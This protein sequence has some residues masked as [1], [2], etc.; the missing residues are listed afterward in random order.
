MCAVNLVAMARESLQSV[1]LRCSVMRLSALLFGAVTSVLWLLPVGCCCAAARPTR[2]ILSDSFIL[3]DRFSA[4][5]LGFVHLSLL[6]A[7]DSSTLPCRSSLDNLLVAAV[8]CPRGTFLGSGIHRE[9]SSLLVSVISV[10]RRSST[11]RSV[12]FFKQST[13]AL[14]LRWLRGDSDGLRCPLLS[15]GQALS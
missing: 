5:G 9:V 14:R 4:G 12:Y 3:E 11:R 10:Y 8:W 1:C 13:S 6:V 2:S 15:V 7:V